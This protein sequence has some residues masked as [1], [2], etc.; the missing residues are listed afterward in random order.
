MTMHPFASRWWL[1]WLCTGSVLVLLGCPGDP[2][3]AGADGPLSAGGGLDCSGRDRTA[4]AC[5]DAKRCT[6]DADCDQR[7]CDLA[8][9]RC[10]QQSHEDG[11]QNLGETGTDCGGTSA[12]RRCGPGERCAAT[13]DC[14]NVICNATTRVCDA[15]SGTD[16]LRNGTESDVD[17]GGTGPGATPCPVDALCRD[18]ADCA[19]LGCDDRGR[20]AAGKSCT[21]KLGGRTCGEGEL[22]SPTSDPRATHESCCARVELAGSTAKLGKYHVTAGR[23]R[24]FVLRENGKIRDWVT[25][26]AVPGFTPASSALVPNSIDEANSQLGSY[27]MGAP[28]DR[29]SGQSKRSCDPDYA[30]GHTYFTNGAG[31]TASD[32]TQEELDV[33]ALNCVG[34]H[35]F[36]AFCA[37]DGGRVPTEAEL[38]AAYKNGGTT[39]YPWGDDFDGSRLN[40]ARNSPFPVKPGRRMRGSGADAYDADIAVFVSAPGRRPSGANAKGAHDVAGNLLHWTSNAEYRF[41]WTH[42]WE[43]HEDKGGTVGSDDWQRSWPEEPNG[44]YAI[45]GRCIYD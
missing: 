28:N 1:S 24:Q 13:A 31:E 32:Y 23:M 41:N 3:E 10:A 37:W 27:W 42:S 26:A 22:P 17:C 39:S 18:H 44:Y 38:V 45:G 7:R 4:G 5:N 34:W 35:L 21:Q 11:I 16:G 14:D 8:S 15:P 36:K 29:G 30:N 19:S 43:N 40:H 33:K 2:T 25:K 12:P 6:S 20:C 9:S